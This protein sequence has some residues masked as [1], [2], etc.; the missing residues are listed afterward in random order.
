MWEHRTLLVY[1]LVV[2]RLKKHLENFIDKS[3]V[4]NLLE[5]I[6]EYIKIHIEEQVKSGATIIQIFD[7][8]AGL[9]KDKDVKIYC[10]QLKNG[11]IYTRSKNTCICF[12]K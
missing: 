8:W 9:V 6:I 12:P 4:D 3:K 7:S 11:P 1:M 5:L 10:N 2:N